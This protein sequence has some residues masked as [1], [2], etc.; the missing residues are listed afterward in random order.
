MTEKFRP[1]S[2]T[3]E[4]NNSGDK[5]L[6]FEV[7]SA[8]AKTM[9]LLAGLSVTAPTFAKS[10]DNKDKKVIIANNPEQENPE[11]EFFS[12]WSLLTPEEAQKTLEQFQNEERLRYLPQPDATKEGRS[13]EKIQSLEALSEG[14]L[15]VTPQSP[16]WIR[17][18]MTR[19]MLKRQ[20]GAT[21]PL[22]LA[23][24]NGE[25]V[26]LIVGVKHSV[27]G[28]Y[29]NIGDEVGMV[30]DLMGGPGEK[31]GL[32]GEVVGEYG[33]EEAKFVVMKAR[34]GS[35]GTELTDEN[36]W[37]DVRTLVPETEPINTTEENIA[38]FLGQSQVYDITNPNLTPGEWIYTYNHDL[39]GEQNTLTQLKSFQDGKSLSIPLQNYNPDSLTIGLGSSGSPIVTTRTQDITPELMQK[40]QAT[41]SE[42]RQI[43]EN[44]KLRGLNEAGSWIGQDV[45][46]Q[47][48][49]DISRFISQIESDL[50]GKILTDMYDLKINGAGKV[51]VIGKTLDSLTTSI[52]EIDAPLP[53]G[54]KLEQNYPNPFN[55]T[56]KISFSLP[57]S[58]YVQLKIFDLLGS[59][60]KTI[61]N[62]W[63]PA[64]R[65]EVQFRADNLPSGMY[66]YQLQAGENFTSKKMMLVR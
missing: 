39:R 5:K 61:V 4:G 15:R 9:M 3:P 34:Y 24:I 19:T 33:I 22:M 23:E 42:A 65:Y 17:E 66:I 35:L 1:S 10:T 46:V 53:E 36:D 30:G 31:V 63:K 14:A 37:L 29:Q 13:L 45:E 41:L 2:N 47:H 49:N 56:T 54:Y 60:I 43:M 11:K 8:K 59:E 12:Q 7:S 16:Q 58:G 38:Y 57:K 28:I 20:E 6:N 48:L 50:G 55:P 62:G 40:E 44:T 51:E 26:V 64:G 25:K 32:W 27:N 21:F 52:E 18:M